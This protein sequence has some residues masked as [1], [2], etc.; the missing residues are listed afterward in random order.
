MMTLV[1]NS[2]EQMIKNIELGE[3][4]MDF[5][6]SVNIETEINNYRKQLRSK[7]FYDVKNGVYSY[8]L[9]VFY[10]DF[11]SEC[12]KLGDYVINVVQA[13]RNDL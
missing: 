10:M 13:T 12:E 3:H 8:Q 6:S 11:I 2:L 5:S 7:N 9:G 1:D 4:E